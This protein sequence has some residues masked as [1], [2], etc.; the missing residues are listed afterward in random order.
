MGGLALVAA[1]LAQEVPLQRAEELQETRQQ[2]REVY[3]VVQPLAQE[4][5]PSTVWIWVGNK[6][7]ALGTVIGVGERVLTKW[8][9]VAFAQQRLRV[10]GGDGRMSR[11]EVIGVYEEDDLAL[12]QLEDETFSAVTWSE[13]PAPALGSFLV[14]A[15][16][17]GLAIGVG[18]VAVAERSLRDADQAFIG[19]ILDQGH[20]GAGIRVRE[21]TPDGAA[22][23]AGV[24]VGD[25]ILELDG[26]A[27]ASPFELRNALLDYTPG[28][29]AVL[30]LQRE[31]RTLSLDVELAPR[32]EFPGVPEGRLRAMRRMGGPVS[33]VGGGFP[34]VIQT[35]MKL[36]RERCGGPVMDLDGEVIG[37][38]IARTDRTRSFVI[39]AARIREL[40]AVD[41]TDPE[42]AQPPQDEMPTQ[43]GVRPI[44][45]SPGAAGRLQQHL[46]EMSRFLRRFDREMDGIGR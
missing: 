45:M 25:V 44:P 2:A 36:T 17:D 3:D 27:V 28:D 41:P 40:L 6:Q 10:V 23:K 22:E 38:S 33:L 31:G 18:V 46:E 29:V 8:S 13:R 37:L 32:P 26:T 9:E 4:V 39:P 35:D 20:E 42:Q 11:A 15:A 21:T 43:A 12:L 1:G 19:V 34:Q 14:A 30:R 5:A 24:R 16:P 7:V